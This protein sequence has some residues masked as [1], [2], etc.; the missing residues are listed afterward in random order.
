MLLL[1]GCGMV[2]A[3]EGAVADQVSSATPS[4]ITAPKPSAEQGEATSQAQ[5][6]PPPE[7]RRGVRAASSR[8]RFRPES[9]DLPGAPSAP[10]EP[11]QTVDGELRIPENVGRVGW[12]DGS[13]YAGDPF[14]STVIAGHIDSSE[15]GLG[16][17]TRLLSM[18]VDQV[19][20]LRSGDHQQ[21]YRVVST[22]LVDKDALATDTAAFDQTGG[23]RLV[24]ITCSGRWRPELGSYES[25]FV[26]VA[27]PLG[28]AT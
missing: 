23:H 4:A 18:Q 9:L 24:L 21:R 6:R 19:V 7:A 13:A 15:Q 12:W 28:P 25:N 1:A 10:V 5:G 22:S 14:G 11:V 17:F 20:T 2:N 3:Q 16:I 27:E 26:V 8:V